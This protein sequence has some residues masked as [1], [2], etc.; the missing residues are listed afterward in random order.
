MSLIEINAD[1]SIGYKESINIFS[2]SM[3]SCDALPVQIYPQR[4]DI[5]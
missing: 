4:E 1:S 2:T 5:P 3:K